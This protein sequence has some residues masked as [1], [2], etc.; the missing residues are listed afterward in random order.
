MKNQHIEREFKKQQSKPRLTARDLRHL[1]EEHEDLFDDPDE[2]Y[3]YFDVM[4]SIGYVGLWSD[5]SVT[6]HGRQIANVLED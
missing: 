5:G 3:G 4:T 1:R 6:F 2:Q